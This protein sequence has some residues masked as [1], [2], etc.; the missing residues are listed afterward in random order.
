MKHTA[1]AAPAGLSSVSNPSP[2]PRWAQRTGAGLLWAALGLCSLAAQ[3]QN[4]PP[5]GQPPG[6]PPE[7]VAAC[8]GKTV[9]TACSFT[10]RQ[11][12]TL[13]GQCATAPSGPPGSSSSSASSSSSSSSS[14]LA[15]R[16]SNMPAPR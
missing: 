1:Q 13:S 15:C 6:P 14:T 10:G 9:G 16:P 4:G 7:A 2:A 12:D 8:T 5:S 3:A 11:N